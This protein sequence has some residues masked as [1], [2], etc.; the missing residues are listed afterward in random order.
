[1]IFRSCFYDLK[2]K[3]GNLCSV[4]TVKTK[5]VTSCLKLEGGRSVQILQSLENARN[6][7]GTGMKLEFCFC[8]SVL[9]E[10]TGVQVDG[11]K[12]DKTNVP[13]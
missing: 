2:G 8:R 5:G 9:E 6:S 7:R 3:R 11:G 10:N 1:M 4:G 13:S 12:S